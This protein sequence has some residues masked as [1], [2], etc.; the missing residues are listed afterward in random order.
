MSPAVAAFASNKESSTG[1]I[2]AGAFTRLLI[3]HI[4]SLCFV[5]TSRFCRL[6]VSFSLKWDNVG[7]L[8]ALRL[9]VA[10]LSGRDLHGALPRW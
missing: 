8:R 5:E 10:V 2:S 9:R 6:C 3:L 1:C 7:V 4:F